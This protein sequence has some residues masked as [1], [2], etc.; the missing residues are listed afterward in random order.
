M[1]I[2]FQGYSLK[3][4]ANLFP[5]D[6]SN[7]NNTNQSLQA[8]LAQLLDYLLPEGDEADGVPI[9]G[10]DLNDQEQQHQPRDLRGHCDDD[11]QQNRHEIHN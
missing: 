3:A 5:L 10:E 1:D 7:N 2:D 9:V 4:R 11:R 8:T 6:S